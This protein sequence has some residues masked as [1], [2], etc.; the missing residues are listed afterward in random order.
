VLDAAIDAPTPL[1]SADF[2]DDGVVDGA[3]FLT[4]QRGAGL[5]GQTTNANGDANGDGMVDEFDLGVWRTQFGGTVPLAIGAGA[6]VPEP[7]ALALFAMAM[8]GLTS[9]RRAGYIGRR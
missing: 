7:A 2:N 1:D 5:E 3:D 4:W 9:L 6:A 8:A